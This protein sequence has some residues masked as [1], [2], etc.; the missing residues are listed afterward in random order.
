[1]NPKDPKPK[2]KIKSNFIGLKVDDSL[3]SSITE[4]ALQNERTLSAQIRVILCSHYNNKT[5]N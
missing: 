5:K 1:M 4:D 2:K 3:L